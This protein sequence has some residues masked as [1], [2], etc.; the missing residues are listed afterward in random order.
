M[1]AGGG[2]LEQVGAARHKC[3]FQLLRMT[4]KMVRASGVP[5]PI[6]EKMLRG[7]VSVNMRRLAIKTLIVVY[8][9][10]HFF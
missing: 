9:V 7:A 4:F 10:G 5:G 8:H 3:V 6:L 2:I 1:S